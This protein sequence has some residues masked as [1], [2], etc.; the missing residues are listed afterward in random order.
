MKENSGPLED[1]KGDII[2]EGERMFE[3]L[4]EYFSTS[5]QMSQL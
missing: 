3:I 1:E 4:N 5:T 2:S